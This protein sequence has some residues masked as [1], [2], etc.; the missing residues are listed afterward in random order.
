MPCPVL[1]SGEGLGPLTT[2]T[3]PGLLLQALDVHW[4]KVPSAH[5]DI[6]VPVPGTAWLGTDGP[7]PLRTGD[8]TLTIPCL[9]YTEPC[10]ALVGHLRLEGPTLR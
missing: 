2:C 10:A 6:D 3:G 4:G 1:D 7:R 5:F 9:S 8:V